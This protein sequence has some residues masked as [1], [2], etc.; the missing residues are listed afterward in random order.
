MQ[1]SGRQQTVSPVPRIQT[2]ISNHPTSAS[3]Q[4]FMVTPPH[5]PTMVARPVPRGRLWETGIWGIH[6]SIMPSSNPSSYLGIST[7]R[8]I[9]R[10]REPSQADAAS[11][12]C[13]IVMVCA[14]SWKDMVCLGQ[15]TIFTT[16]TARTFPATPDT[17]GQP[18]WMQVYASRRTAYHQSLIRALSLRNHSCA[19]SSRPAGPSPPRA[20]ASRRIGRAILRGNGECKIADR[21]NNT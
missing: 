18:H 17:H 5:H 19:A 13:E 1:V 11:L 20:D 16:E 7:K 21:H 4:R 2:A 14:A 8:P 6:R 12:R 9:G 3:G 10:P 15:L